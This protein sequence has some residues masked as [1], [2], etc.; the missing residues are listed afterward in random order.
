MYVHVS[1]KN[2]A[3]IKLVRRNYGVVFR[4]I[5]FGRAR[6]SVSSCIQIIIGIR[7]MD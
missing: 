7:K 4:G 3:V 5:T 6:N 2:E 1:L